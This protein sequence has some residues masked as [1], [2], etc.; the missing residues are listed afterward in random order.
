MLNKNVAALAALLTVGVADGGARVQAKGHAPVLLA[1]NDRTMVAPKLPPL[2]T[3]APV[4]TT[5]AKK[6]TPAPQPEPAP[7]PAAAPTANENDNI[8]DK[9]VIRT[10][11]Q[12]HLPEIQFC[13]EQ[14]L[15]ET[16]KLGGKFVVKFTIVT[17]DGVGRVSDGE[18]VPGDEGYLES[19]S[20][21]S[22][23][24][25]AFSRWHFPPSRTGEDVVVSYP[26][27]FKAGDEAE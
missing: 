24:L 1:K 22:C 21:Q 10:T 11:V 3:R 2:T 20:M 27:V 18:I 9:D 7:K 25:Q 8:L 16:P 4:K 5:S 14:A 19:L 15:K 12:K 17:K 6:P 23:V 13:Y 26:L